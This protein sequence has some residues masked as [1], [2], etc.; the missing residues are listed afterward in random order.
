MN[1]KTLIIWIV[2]VVVIFVAILALILNNIGQGVNNTSQTSAVNSGSV[3]QNSVPVNPS[4]LTNSTSSAVL[5]PTSIPAV[6]TIANDPGLS[7]LPGSPEAPKQ[8]IVATDNVPTSAVKIKVSADGFNPKTFT[9]KSGQSVTLAL[10]STDSGTHAFLF[11]TASLMG[12]TTMVSGEETKIIT[13]KAPAVG[14]YSFRDD[15]PSFRSNTGTM[16]VK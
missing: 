9:I 5:A 10:T 8:E 3:P 15:I 1:K 11:P 2:V 7:S 4:A 16:I 13:F 6:A 14:S 12:L